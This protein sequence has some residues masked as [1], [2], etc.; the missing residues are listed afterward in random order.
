MTSFEI[1]EYNTVFRNLMNYAVNAIETSVSR[2]DMIIMQ[3]FSQ[4]QAVFSRI[5]PPQSLEYLKLTTPGSVLK[6]QCPHLTI[7]SFS[8]M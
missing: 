3:S 2:E 1:T 4:G 7:Q 5:I 8:A 6:T